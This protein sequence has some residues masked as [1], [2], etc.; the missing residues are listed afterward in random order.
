MKLSG[1]DDWRMKKCPI[2]SFLPEC[3]PDSRE[4]VSSLFGITGQMAMVNIYSSG[5]TQEPHR[6][7]SESSPAVLASVP[8]RL[9]G[10]CH[11]YG[12]MKRGW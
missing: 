2:G 11:H 3:L 4:F 7:I 1:Q 5:D 8:L 6:D 9:R 12:G 10:V